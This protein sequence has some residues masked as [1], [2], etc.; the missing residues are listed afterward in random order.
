MNN[1][2]LTALFVFTASL[3]FFPHNGYAEFYWG[4]ES[5][6]TTQF[7]HRQTPVGERAQQT[8][9][10][11]GQERFNGVDGV[12]PGFTDWNPANPASNVAYGFNRGAYS[13]F[14][15]NQHGLSFG[16]GDW[17]AMNLLRLSIGYNNGKIAFGARVNLDRLVGG[18]PAN[19]GVGWNDFF[20]PADEHSF[21]TGD[22]RTPNWSAF[23]RYGFEEYY[24]RAV[25]GPLLGFIGAA[26][27]RGKVQTFNNKNE[28]L[29]GGG[30]MV[31]NFG[32][33][34]PNINADFVHDGLDTN[35]L[36]RGGA[37]DHSDEAKVAS[38]PY[39]MLALSLENR[40][41]FPLTFQLAAD[42]GNNSG[43]GTRFDLDY[44]SVRGMFRVSAENIIDRINIDAIY[45]I[46]GGDRNTM[47]IRNDPNVTY[48]VFQPNGVGFL[49]HNFGVYAN[50]M[51][52]FGFNFG[53]GY[54]A[55]L[56]TL[57]SFKRIDTGVVATRTS[58]MFHGF[59]LRIQYTGIR[60][61]VI[62][63]F[64]NI[65]FAQTNKSSADAY[66]FG[67][68]GVLLPENVSQSWLAFYNA[69]TVTYNFSNRFFATVQAASR[70]GVITNN[71]F[72]L[73]NVVFHE[74][75]V[76]RRTRLVVGGGALL[77]YRFSP[78]A[79]FQLGVVL[80]YIYQSY[81]NSVPGAQNFP[82]TRNA[83]GGTFDIAFPVNLLFRIQ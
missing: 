44:R 22:G 54:S 26:N 15:V 69:L 19:R 80:R 74:D 83:S 38:L 77:S 66:V 71:G 72:L 35:N 48:G 50:I 13:F 8:I 79:N 70:Y 31:E 39:F 27:D 64:H 10:V 53:I 55:Y 68:T 20:A 14:T 6:F 17:G 45:K 67:L 37:P 65:S 63:S 49:I 59:D 73:N 58:P 3:V 12:M 42:P 4:L 47:D 11:G 25:A 23:L 32:V 30:L 28:M 34:A 43:I 36:L 40:L 41:P 16:R 57:E 46:S 75:A 78:F 7:F 61:L 18:N 9:I 51:N 81:S 56:E 33:N 62:T 2:F 29:L 60:N 1:K 24:V 5:R 52:I 76:V 21:V 82:V